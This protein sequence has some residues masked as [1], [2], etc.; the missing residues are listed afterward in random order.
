MRP[1]RR[2]RIVFILDDFR[3]PSGG[4]TEVQ[5]IN[6]INSLSR[7]E[8]DP[9]VVVLRETS[10][11]RNLKDYPFKISCL[12]IEKIF[13]VKALAAMLSFSRQL[14]SEKVD[15]V[16]IFFNDASILA[17]LFAKLGGGRVVSSRRDM[18]FWYTPAKL[19][20]LFLSNLFV[21]GMVANSNAVKVNVN[22]RERYPLAR[23]HVIYNG[24]DMGRFAAAR[25]GGLR[26]SLGLGAG[27]AIVGMVAN[28]DGIKR[29]QDLIRAFHLVAG[30]FP[31]AHLVL[32][33]HGPEESSLR[34]LAG[35]LGMTSRVRFLGSVGDVLPVIADLDVA[36]L[37]SESEGLSNAIIECMGC[38]KPVICTRTGGNPELVAEGVNG[39]LVDVGDVTGL[40]EKLRLLLSQRD[41]AREL[42]QNGARLFADRF[43]I[44]KMADEH[45]ALYRRLVQGGGGRG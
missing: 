34:K 4:G 30:E 9:Q 27:D 41:H 2:L 45:L 15:V 16:H 19:A 29:H 23:V 35:E 44:K 18:G 21:D 22:Q 43:S 33:G 10:Y 7:D 11:T 5:F 31:A 6:L 12:D 39:Y 17:P 36:V 20:C 37:C 38:G 25:G 40:A 42:G 3:G 24:I 1:K 14:R 32:A 13:S 8:T 26:A 28:L